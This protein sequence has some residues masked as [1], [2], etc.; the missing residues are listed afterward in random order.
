MCGAVKTHSVKPRKITT[1]DHHRDLNNCASFIS[2]DSCK[3]GCILC[4][5]GRIIWIHPC[6]KY[7]NFYALVFWIPRY[8][9][10]RQTFSEVPSD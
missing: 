6:C 5:S 4:S 2:L 9:M 10:S 1:A 3:N 7:I 8:T